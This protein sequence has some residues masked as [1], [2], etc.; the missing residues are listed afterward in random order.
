VLCPATDC[1]SDRSV[2]FIKFGQCH[3][4]LSS[5]VCEYLST[6]QRPKCVREKTT[7]FAV[8]RVTRRQIIRAA[9]SSALEEVTKGV[10]G[11]LFRATS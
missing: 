1:Y 10:G 8:T 4:G 7:Q 11:G 6:R 2:N 9:G 5:Y 3:P